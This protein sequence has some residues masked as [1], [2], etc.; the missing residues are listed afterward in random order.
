ME[1]HGLRDTTENT[2]NTRQFIQPI[3]PNW[4][5]IWDIFEK[6]P[7]HI[8]IVQ[9]CYQMRVPKNQQDPAILVNGKT[10]KLLSGKTSFLTKLFLFF[11][12]QDITTL[13]MKTFSSTY[14]SRRYKGLGGILS[15]IDFMS[16]EI[17]VIL[18]RN[19]LYNG[20]GVTMLG[21]YPKVILRNR[22][23]VKVHIF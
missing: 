2:S 17:L 14:L 20:C 16:L 22:S 9:A 12:P 10:N 5:I 6:S 13:Y 1:N 15:T 8:S 19:S 7:H 18:L 23:Y 4:P 21:M 3:Y 11:L